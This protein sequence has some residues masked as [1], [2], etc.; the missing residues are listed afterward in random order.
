MDESPK[1][2]EGSRR[3]PKWVL[4]TLAVALGLVVLA[5]IVAQYW[6]HGNHLRGPLVRYIEAHTGREIR[7]EGP[8]EMQLFSRHPFVKAS[9]VTVGN[10]PWSEPGNLAE[11]ESL[12]AVF[13]VSFQ[14]GATLESLELHGA[15]FHLKRD[16]AGHA[17]WHWKAP[18][19]LPG[20]G[21]PAIRSLSA[22]AA[23][24][25]LHDERRH[26]DFDGTLTT[27]NATAEDPLRLL[28]KGQLNGHEVTVTLDGEPLSKV[29]PDKPF[30][31]TFDERSSDTHLTGHGT[32]PHPFNFAWLDADYRASGQDLKDLRYL[33][34]VSL[35]DSAQYQLSGKLERRNLT[36]KLVDLVVVSGKSDAHLNLTSVLNS[37]GRAHVDIDLDTNLLRLQDLGAKAAGR[38]PLEPTS[39]ESPSSRTSTKPPSTEPSPPDKAL[40]LPDT[41]LHF[42]ALRRTD[43][44]VSLHA[45]RFETEKLSFTAVAGKMSIDHGNITVSPLSGTLDGGKLDAHIK[46]DARTDTPKV[47][48]DLT[49]ANLEL[50]QLPRKN[51]SQPPPLEGLLQGKVELN[52]HGK[53]VRD[54]AAGANGTVTAAI[55]QGAIR[56]SFAELAGV[57][58]R[59]VGLMLTKNRKDTAIRCG[60]ASFQAH[61]GILTAQTLVLD[62]DAVLITGSGTVEL[63]S[64]TLD[65]ELEGHPKELR[66]L[67]I[68]APISVQGPLNHLHLA[69]E[70]GQRKFKL[71][72]PGH[73]KDVD[74]GALLTSDSHRQ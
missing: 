68:S 10:P 66:V 19:I 12:T 32:L 45:K 38:A 64:R 72:D 44:A 9:R 20:K 4:G 55:P 54:L 74:C 56:D 15:S 43:Y 39:S 40:S 63:A 29:A 21:L 26:L 13:D 8:L 57:D 67:R 51:P 30:H 16:I 7:I 62:T 33:A 14:H 2:L 49:V 46:L 53:S 58:L 37:E 65:L 48:V 52:S 71:I 22:P 11:V 41:P 1:P 5:V 69:L 60:L 35:P 42:A 28:A 73:A 27:Q 24:V 36:F 59:G 70:K 17:N 61:D 31:F 34:G 50:G 6:L 23:H 47:S 25:D 18:G 3:R